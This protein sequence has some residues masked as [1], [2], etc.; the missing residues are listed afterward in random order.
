VTPVSRRVALKCA[1]LIGT[2][3][4][5]STGLL[6]TSGE[7]TV[8]ASAVA[9]FY[10]PL[11]KEALTAGTA[12][13]LECRGALGVLSLQNQIVG[14]IPINGIVPA[15]ITVHEVVSDRAGRISLFVRVSRRNLG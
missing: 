4:A 3:T 13:S 8:K 6:D 2:G 14:L 15:R 10:A 7:L 12:L 9:A 5:V 11:L 1:G